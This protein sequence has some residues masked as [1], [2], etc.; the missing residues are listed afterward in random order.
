MSESKLAML[1]DRE[2]CEDEVEAWLAQET[3]RY[4]ASDLVSAAA[5]PRRAVR[6]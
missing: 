6:R 5:S 2:A 3:R 1:A 4:P